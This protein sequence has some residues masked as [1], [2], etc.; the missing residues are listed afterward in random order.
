MAQR[1]LVD[2]AAPRPCLRAV[3]GA[4]LVPEAAMIGWIMFAAIV[5]IVLAALWRFAGLGREV[6]IFVFAAVMLAAAGYAWQGRPGEPAYPVA[7][8]NR[9]IEVDPELTILRGA[10]TERFGSDA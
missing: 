10:M 4:R 1:A 7:T 5:L 2:R 8:A 3:A 6:W 9:M